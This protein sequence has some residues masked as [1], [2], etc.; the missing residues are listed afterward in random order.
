[1]IGRLNLNIITPDMHYVRSY[2]LLK[3]HQYEL[4]YYIISNIKII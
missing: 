4:Y 3:I 1:M 2:K